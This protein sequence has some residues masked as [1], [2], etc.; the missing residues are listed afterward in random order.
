MVGIDLHKFDPER[1]LDS[2]DLE[3]LSDCQTTLSDHQLFFG[4]LIDVFQ[5]DVS[6]CGIACVRVY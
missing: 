6:G 3:P 2:H 5:P 4:S 1:S